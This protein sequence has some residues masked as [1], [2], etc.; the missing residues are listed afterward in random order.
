MWSRIRV[1]GLPYFQSEA[2]GRAL[3]GGLVLVA[4]LVAINGLD[5]VNSFVGRDFMS[6]LAERHAHRFFVFAGLLAGVFAVS[7]IVEVLARYAE[8]RLGLL[9]RDWLTRRF[10]DR[11]LARRAYLR[12]AERHD[13][14]NPDQR[15]SEDV[16]TFTA[17]TLS[18]LV[19]LVQ[20][21]LTLLA[22]SGVLWS[23]TPWL[24]LIALGYAAAGSLG[25]ILLGRRLVS[26]NNQQLQ[27]EADFRYALGRVREHAEAIAQVAGEEEQ[28]G[29]LGQRLARVVENFRTIIG[30]SRNLAFFTTGYN[31][32]PQ[33][34]PAAVVAHLYIQGKV[35]FGAVTQ[36]AMAFAQVQGA[37]SLIVNEF[38]VV[39]TYAAVI[40]RLGSLWE[41]TEPG[42]AGS[43]SA[44]SLPRKPAKKGVAPHAGQVEGRDGPVV[45]MTTDATRVVYEHLTLW[46]PK[47]P[48]P[49]VRDLSLELSE[50]HRV[51]LLGPRGAPEIAMLAT[52][53]LWPEGQGWIHRP[54]PSSLV[55]VPQRPCLASGQLPDILSDCLGGEIPEERYQAVLRDVGLDE[56]VARE[57]GLDAVRDW[58]KALSAGEL[59]A[60][61]F[62]R[63]L[64]ASPRFAFLDNPAG[65]L[66]ESLG[67]RL[68]MALARS[69]ISYV[70]VDCPSALLAYHNRLVQIHQDGSWKEE[71]G[72]SLNGFAP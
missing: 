31:Y 12:L 21:A 53:G 42:V 69:S 72:G 45:E 32:L 27:K 25:T 57:G 40:G 15:I 65:M 17:T 26:L 70:S 59:Q 38:Q 55:F 13:I 33:I 34:I 6:A 61:T 60:L 51:A 52:A 20:G 9:W 11:Y 24:F 43:E 47:D 58:A 68:Y 23:I 30:V 19:L 28:K 63:L 2:R 18:F 41:A 16:K 37:F 71:P 10:L 7:T 14:D 48:R 44:G 56:A 54:G 64:L 49:I 29:R 66:E 3:A 35:E 50:G 5:V 39:T 4:L 22:F 8:Q 67:N 1:I 62:A 46:T 36:A